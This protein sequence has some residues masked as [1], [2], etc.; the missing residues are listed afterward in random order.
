MQETAIFMKERLA[1]R[2]LYKA[3]H[4]VLVDKVVAFSMIEYDD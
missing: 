3:V 4:F 2:K 1:A